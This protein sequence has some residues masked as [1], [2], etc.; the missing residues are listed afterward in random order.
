M[1]ITSAERLK[2]LKKHPAKLTQT[3]WCAGRPVGVATAA[4][5]T[6]RGSAVAQLV[7]DV[8]L[9]CTD[10]AIDARLGAETQLTVQRSWQHWTRD[11]WIFHTQHGAVI[12][13]HRHRLKVC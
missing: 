8:T 6:H 10:G 11:S 1:A 2:V 7:P 9:E 13:T 3:R 12:I 4:K 5:L